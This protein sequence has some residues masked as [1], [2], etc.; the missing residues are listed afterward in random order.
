MPSSESHQPKWTNSFLD[1]MRHVGDPLADGVVTNLFESGG[2]YSV[3]ELMKMLVQNDYTAPDQ[4]P[5]QLKNYLEETSHVPSAEPRS[6]EKAQRLFQRFG[7]EI[8]MVLACYSLPASYAARKGVQVLYRTGYLNHRPNR[9]LF[10]TAQM[11]M[12]VMTPGG[13][14]GS[15]R[16]IRTA[17]KVRLMHASIRLLTLTDP[18]KSWDQQLGV[19]INQEDLAGTMMLFTYVIIDGLDRLGIA[20]SDA[21]QHG[22]LETWK[23]IAR[24]LGIQEV[25][26]PLSMADAKE[27][28]ELIQ[29]RQV[30]P[31]PE[32]KAMN[33]ALLQMM[34]RQLPPGPWRMWPAALMRHFLPAEIANGFEIPHH[35]L[36]EQIV[37]SAE[38]F[39]G[40]LEPLTRETDRRLWIV[41]KFALC[42]LQCLFSLELGGKRTPFIIPTNLH[43]GWVDSHRV[44]VWSQLRR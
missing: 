26:L 3:S 19:P 35:P 14:N 33:D 12:D 1:E 37:R 32:G 7:A 20:T 9:R 24:V 17:Q 28:C 41:R 30:Q 15:G 27:L 39:R 2:L 31:S 4:L 11:V 25:L 5:H 18:E 40:T 21:E 34:E 42:L 13:L 10:E 38:E 29:T 16:G 23:V 6:F 43:R 36:G 22:F 44:S 8:L